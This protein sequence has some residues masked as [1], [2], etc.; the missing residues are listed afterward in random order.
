ML[1]I[2]RSGCCTDPVSWGPV[3]DVQ[4]EPLQSCL[5]MLL[6]QKWGVQASLSV[7]FIL[8]NNVLYIHTGSKS[9]SPSCFFFITDINNP[10]SCSCVSR[11]GDLIASLFS[12]Y[13]WA[14]RVWVEGRIHAVSTCSHLSV[15]P[16]GICDQTWL[17]HHLEPRP[18]SSLYHPCTFHTPRTSISLYTLWDPCCSLGSF[19]FT[20]RQADLPMEKKRAS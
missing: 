13:P 3:G 14:K 16:P 17:Q 10:T 15:G 18:W 2:G 11:T 20:Y 1:C 6:T 5:I 12:E 9:Q 8:Y 4:S 19:E 7:L